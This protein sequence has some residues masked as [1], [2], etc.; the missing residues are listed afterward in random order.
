MTHLELALLNYLLNSLW[1]VPL[2]FLAASLAVRLVR[3]A[4][5]LVEHRIW[6][7]ALALEVALPAC[8]FGPVLRNLFFSLF[9]SRSGSVTTQ[10][11]LLDV[12]AKSRGGSHLAAVAAPTALIAYAATLLFFSARLLYRLHR[13]RTLHRSA[14]PFTLTGDPLAVWQRC[15]RLF[16]IH[17]AQLAI[18]DAIASPSTIGV[19]RR[20]V[21]LP[22]ALLSGHSHED[23]AAAVAHEF[24][25]MRRRDFAKNL[26]YELIALPIAFH[27]LFWLT[28]LRIAESREM[29]CDQLAAHATHGASRYAHSLLRLAASFS[30]PTPEPNHAIGILDANA[31][32]RRVMKLTRN[33]IYSASARRSAIVAAIAL[34]IATCASAMS[35]RFEIPEP[36][37]AASAIAAPL[38][39]S[40]GPHQSAAPVRIAGGVAAGQIVSKVNPVYPPEAKQQGIQG[41][42]VLHAVI[43]ADG[44]VQQLDVVSGPQE[45][46]GS[47]VE[48]VKQWVYKPFLLNGEPVAVDTTIT[49]NYSL[50]N[51]PHGSNSADERSSGPAPSSADNLAA[52]VRNVGG[53][54]RP[55]VLLFGPDPKYSPQARTAKFSGKVV[56][57]LTVDR[58]GIAR[59]VHVVRGVGMGLDENAVA[60][61]QKYRFK[62]ATQ[63]GEP[64]ATRLSVEVD[65]RYVN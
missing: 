48:A 28:R 34:G 33:S 14:H 9:G 47:A 32:E 53:S 57:G 36:A 44:T 20:I 60:A 1:Q 6:V 43:G 55:P 54:V 41:S 61:V 64:V 26:V 5:P 11:T 62:P 42:V 12:S 27:P 13:T 29:V 35:L 8:A 51:S 30:R 15:S 52:D 16:A 22:R 45:L 10:L 38:I 37:V 23:F 56:V 46:Q 19:R 3:S 58:D 2:V 18:S 50:D 49:V 59:D 24:A 63:N 65:F 25:H 39:A 7:A 40:A 4:G 17:D 31:L 21:L